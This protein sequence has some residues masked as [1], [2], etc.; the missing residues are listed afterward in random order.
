MFPGD[1][2][3]M[4]IFL[5]AAAMETMGTPVSQPSSAFGLLQGFERAPLWVIWLRNIPVHWIHRLPGD[6]QGLSRPAEL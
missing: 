3:G 1:C 4:T 6:P 5:L 2:Q